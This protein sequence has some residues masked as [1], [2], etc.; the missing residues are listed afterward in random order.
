MS[1]YEATLWR[2]AYQILS[3]LRCLDRRKPSERL[4]SRLA[5]DRWSTHEVA[6]TSVE[7]RKISIAI[8]QNCRQ[9]R[10]V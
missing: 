10:F 2:Q 4:G 8:E 5:R 3:T 9:G 1:R 7:T 6:R